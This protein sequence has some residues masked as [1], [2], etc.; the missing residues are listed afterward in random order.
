MSNLDSLPKDIE[1]E[2][3]VIG[4]LLLE[5]KAYYDVSSILSPDDFYDEKHKI[6]YQSIQDL[7]SIDENIDIITVKDD[8]ERKGKLN[9]IG[10]A[11][12]LMQLSRKVVSTAHIQS[13]ARIVKESSIK[14]QIIHISG[15]LYQDAKDLTKDTK[16][17]LTEAET[18]LFELTTNSIKKDYTSIREP[19]N[20]AFEEIESSASNPTGITG[21]ESGLEDIDRIT[22]GWQPSNLIIIAA[23]PAMGKTALVVTMAKNLAIDRG[24]P[25]GFFS[26]EMSKVELVKRIISSICEISSD[27]VKNG[28]LS[29]FEWKNLDRSRSLIA[30]SPFYIDDTANLSIFE[31]KSKAYRMVREHGVKILFVDYLQLVTASNKSV[32]EQEVAFISRQLKGLAKELDI[33]VIALSQLNRGVEN[34]EGIN[35]RPQLSDLRESG[36]IEQDADIVAFLHRPEYYKIYQDEQGNDLRGIAEL[37]FAKNRHGRVGDVRM[38][39]IGKYTKFESINDRIN[40]LDTL[41]EK[42]L[43]F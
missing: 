13:H 27:V 18:N 23:R 33:P 35:K 26:L 15:K 31:L 30:E 19:L 2:E 7:S 6:I 37:I 8:V 38:R 22:A 4:G 39:F 40:S 14:R 5:K 9:D 41:S 20:E 10:G 34:R 12:T 36:A 29:P 32:R 16:E 17:L 3:A 25:I 28:Q 24:I 1:A 43:P 42:D 21:V 11:F